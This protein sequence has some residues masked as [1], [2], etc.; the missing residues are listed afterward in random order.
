M[1][2]TVLGTAVVG[3]YAIPEWLERAKTDYAQGRLPGEV[4][5]DMHNVVVK[6]A[7]KDQ[8]L[9]GVDVITDGEVRRDNMLDHFTERL[10]GVDVDRRHKAYYYDFADAL[11]RHPI[12]I[13]RLGLVDEF[14]F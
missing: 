12:P 1:G 10:A 2:N 3:S 6:A 11:V 14:T 4:L 8:E 9:A 5:D 13:S 7:V